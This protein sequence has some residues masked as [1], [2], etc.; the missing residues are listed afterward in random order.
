VTNTSEETCLGLI[1]TA[2]KFEENVFE[3]CPRK[4]TKSCEG[5]N[6]TWEDNIKMDHR[7]WM[8]WCQLS[9]ERAQ[10]LDFVKMETNLWFP[11]QGRIS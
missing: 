2:R 10:Y 3:I 1:Q 8:L 9:Q 6:G 5:T 4:I 11:K 7:N